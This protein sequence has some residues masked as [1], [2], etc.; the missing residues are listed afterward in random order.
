MPTGKR[1][2]ISTATA[3]LILA[4]FRPLSGTWYVQQSSAGFAGVQF[5]ASGDKIVPADYDGDGKTDFAVYRGGT[6]YLQRS[7]QG[8]TGIAFGAA[9]D[10]PMP[11]DFDGDGKADLALFR[12]SNGTWYLLESTDGFV[13]VKFGQAGD[14]PVAADY[15]GDGK[16]DLAVF[17]PVKRHLVSEPLP[18]RLRRHSVRTKRRCGR[19]RRL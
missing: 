11:A 5:G 7:S 10:I 18:T 2:S 4:V 8:L 6:W 15:D 14:Q 19:A 13:S 17:R 12:P 3:K 16:A 9:E 1:R